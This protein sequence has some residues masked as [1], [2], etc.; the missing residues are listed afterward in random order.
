MEFLAVG[1][2]GS[3]LESPNGRDWT[4]DSPPLKLDLLGCGTIGGRTVVTGAGGTI[5]VRVKPAPALDDPSPYRLVVPAAVHA[6]GLAGSFWTTGL[7][8]T[9]PNGRA[10]LVRLRFLPR[11]GQPVTV[12]EVIPSGSSVAFDDMVATVFDRPGEAGSVIIDPDEPVVAASRTSSN[13]TAGSAGQILPG[14]TMAQ[15]GSGVAVLPGLAGGPGFRTNIGLVNLGDDALDCTVAIHGSDGTVLATRTATIGPWESAQLNR[16]L[17]GLDTGAG[18]WA[19]VA[20]GGPFATYASVVDFG[21]NDGATVLPSPVTSGPLLIPAAAHAPGYGGALWRTDLDIVNPGQSA[22]S[23]ALEL[24][25]KG[26]GTVS[27][28]TVEIPVGSAVALRDVLGTRFPG[29]TAGAIRIVPVSGEVAAWSR[30]YDVTG[31]GTLGQGVGALALEHRAGG[32]GKLIIG[33]LKGGP[34]LQGW[35]HT[36]L[37]LVN[38]SDQPV[39]VTVKIFAGNGVLLSSLQEDVPAEGWLQVLTVLRTKSVAP[40]ADAYAVIDAGEN[41]AAIVAW[42]SVI[43]NTSGD[44]SF[45]LGRTVPAAPAD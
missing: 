23:V 41:P 43:D 44:P 4:S 22:A 6:P 21:T 26:G 27:G 34:S 30:T 7:F 37:G 13:V 29:H 3:V 32:S 1:D 35:F 42:A 45:L 20:C 24:L 11:E 25:T 17:H 28:G 9:N 12:P 10:A 18:A 39:T 33:G 38:V 19:A 8:L 14:L 5:Q 31:E 2:E 15:T 40:V 36:N 16:V